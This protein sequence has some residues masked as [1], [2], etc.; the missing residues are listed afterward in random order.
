MEYTQ[1]A[2]Y[3]RLHE[4][5]TMGNTFSSV[6]TLD[7][8]P[9]VKS[10]GI[11]DATSKRERTLKYLLRANHHSYAVN[12]SH[13]QA[14]NHLPHTLAS[15]FFLKASVED[16]QELYDTESKSLDAWTDSPEEISEADWRCFLGHKS[17]QRA[18]LDFFEDELVRLDYDWRRVVMKYMLVGPNP[19][20]YGAMGGLGHP[21]IHMG[22]AFELNNREIA[23]EAL[24]LSATNYNFLHGDLNDDFFLRPTQSHEE[25][26][27]G[28][29][30][31]DII[32]KIRLENRINSLFQD[33][34][35]QNIPMLFE[36][37]AVMGL[38]VDFFRE[39][40][41]SDIVGTHRDLCKLATIL[42]CA[43]HPSDSPRYDFLF[44]QILTISYAI[45]TLLP[46]LPHEFARP[47]LKSHWLFALSVYCAQLRPLLQPELINKVNCDMFTCEEITR[48]ALNRYTTKKKILGGH[49]LKVVRILLEYAK[50]WEDDHEFYCRAAIKFTREFDGWS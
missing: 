4:V 32:N 18:Y 29:T 31:L 11:E 36:D 40:S 33:A 26:Q 2:L 17:S 10:A 13:S 3:L 28:T 16:I 8:L 23:M 48:I 41:F 46:Q 22:Y 37:P 47:L 7:G 34:G 38:V 49:F 27:Q 24:V 9:P 35:A 21:L 39:L 19:L 30:A 15:A 5:E 1:F 25:G 45:R 12:N 44:S 42:V 43:A 50:L 6:P 20:I 14:F